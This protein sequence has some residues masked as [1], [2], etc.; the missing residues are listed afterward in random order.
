MINNQPPLMMLAELMMNREDRKMVGDR[1][2]FP[3]DKSYCSSAHD[4]NFTPDP[5]FET[6]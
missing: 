5:P 3:Y 4:Y 2:H 6:H 1:D